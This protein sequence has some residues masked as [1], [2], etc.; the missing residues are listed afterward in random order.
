V[1]LVERG[2]RVPAIHPAEQASRV[3]S[4]R[5]VGMT[6]PLRDDL[7][8]PGVAGGGPCGI[9][10]SLKFEPAAA[11]RLRELWA[12]LNQLYRDGTLA[13]ERAGAPA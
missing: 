7:T 13:D 4:G 3:G 5:R 2:A 9:V 1:L 6:R 12:A 10:V 11:T 8:A